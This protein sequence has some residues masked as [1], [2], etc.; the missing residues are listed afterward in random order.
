MWVL[1]CWEKLTVVD[2]NRE[3]AI[4][5]RM[6]FL[7][8]LAFV[9]SG[10]G[11]TATD[12]RWASVGVG[13]GVDASSVLFALSDWNDAS[14][15]RVDQILVPEED[16]DVVIRLGDTGGHCGLT[17]WDVRPG[18]GQ[19]STDDGRGEILL[20]AEPRDDC[21]IMNTIRHELGHYMAGT[22]LH[23]G[24]PTA[25]MYDREMGQAG[26]TAADLWFVGLK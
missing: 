11:Q 15:G 8:L 12:R 2:F 6:R 16:A 4:P 25:I 9:L 5:R 13:D 21:P 26:I 20:S 24:D 1:F 7:L 18:P 17:R 3:V 22:H 14:G 10:C 23:L 19:W